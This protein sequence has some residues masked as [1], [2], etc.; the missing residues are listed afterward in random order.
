MLAES[1][2][3]RLIDR[4]STILQKPRSRTPLMKA[5]HE[6]Q[7]CSWVKQL[8]AKRITV[9]QNSASGQR[10][11]MAKRSETG[12]KGS[13][14]LFKRWLKPVNWRRRCLKPIALSICST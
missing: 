13:A 3:N 1:E 6:R 2:S 7:K 5:L 14:K 12:V 9:I 4:S 8:K 10:L 11:A